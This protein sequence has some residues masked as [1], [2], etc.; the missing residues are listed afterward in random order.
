MIYFGDFSVDTTQARLFHHDVEVPIEPKLFKLLVLFLENPDQVLARDVLVEHLWSGRYVTDN[1]INKQVAN[2]RKLLNDDPKQPIYI[3][4]VPKLG[5][6]LVCAVQAEKQAPTSQL[7]SQSTVQPLK[8]RHGYGLLISVIGLMVAVCW[9]LIIQPTSI[10]NDTSHTREL[11]R[12]SGKEYAARQVLGANKLLYLRQQLEQKNPEL[13]LKDLSSEQTKRIAIDGFV[14]NRLIA[15]EFR[16]SDRTI[17]VYFVH[18]ADNLCTVYQ[19][20][21][22]DFRL[23]DEKALLQC[24][25]RGFGDIQFD[26]VNNT[27]YF[28]KV[29]TGS[30]TFQLYQFNVATGQQ[31]LLSQ[32]PV[33]G[34]GNYAF[35]LS[36]DK[37]KL[38]V[39][40]INHQSN[41]RLY[42]LNLKSQELKQIRSFDYFV[43]EA[44]WHHNGKHIYY[45][46]APPSN[47]ILLS[48]LAGNDVNSVVSVSDYINRDMS[49][50]T[51]VGSIVFSTRMPNYSHVWFDNNTALK[52]NNSTVYDILPALFHHE[53]RYVFVS[54]RSG[55]SQLYLGDLHSG[56][57]KVVS[58]LS[59]Y[60][61]FRHVQLSNDDQS[62]LVASASHIWRIPRQNI[63]TG[64]IDLHTE[65]AIYVSESTITQINWLNNQTFLVKEANKAESVAV[66]IGK[67]INKNISLARWR[68]VIQDDKTPNVLY[69]IERGTNKL[70]TTTSQHFIDHNGLEQYLTQ[71]SVDLPSRFFDVEVFDKKL[72]FVTREQG[73]FYLSQL[74]LAQST[75][76]NKTKLVGLYGYDIASSG[77][78]ISQ[79]QSLRGDIHRTV[80]RE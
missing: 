50:L 4:T 37:Q 13:W 56:E 53:A 77:I 48:D 20:R 22:V 44:L 28:S 68:Y 17:Y 80:L 72:L 47:Q 39:M 27:L 71:I 26:P 65:N 45:F 14:F 36:P 60:L 79:L 49:R 69:L 67:G 12:Q 8:Q 57:A 11:T 55:K 42:V 25:N 62:L 33:E 73:D 63:E 30:N 66:D 16:E 31:S 74:D 59:Q 18:N 34:L 41:T 5:Y 6:R 1:A 21:I 75:F 52:P 43:S 2:L 61:V 35:D 24:S 70:F 78:I 64:N 9:W 46:A 10:V 15:G 40:N 23:V 58:T 76:H 7:D 3:Q 29:M 32:P 38:L 19:A 54:K 51:E